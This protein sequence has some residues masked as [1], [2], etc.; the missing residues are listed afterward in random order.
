MSSQ[1][2]WEIW[3]YLMQR[4]VSPITFFQE[5][6]INSKSRV[7]SEKIMILCN[8]ALDHIYENIEKSSDPLM[9][10]D[11]WGRLAL[12]RN[13]LDMILNWPNYKLTLPK[14]CWPI[15]DYL[16]EYTYTG[17]LEENNETLIS[18]KK[19]QER[20]YNIVDMVRIISQLKSYMKGRSV[21]IDTTLLDWSYSRYG[22]E[23][24][25]AIF[26]ANILDNAI[27]R[28]Y[29][30]KIEIYIETKDGISYLCIADNGTGIDTSNQTLEQI[31]EKWHSSNGST[32]LW[33]RDLNKRSIKCI[34]KNEGL[35]SRF[36]NLNEIHRYNSHFDWYNTHGA[37]FQVQLSPWENTL[38]K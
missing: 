9:V 15:V 20:N 24:D 2:L 34:V 29:A 33:L 38:E 4:Q 37:L 27:W 25:F 7:L 30:S 36:K 31:F 8:T 5:H 26:I 11:I 23:G 28:G 1:N 17:T 12:F 6:P 14:S 19:S 18:Y 10:H 35:P 3:E 16:L 32:G 22:I 13:K 21:K